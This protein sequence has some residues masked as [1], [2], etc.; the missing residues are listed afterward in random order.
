[1]NRT[2]RAIVAGLVLFLAIAA[3]AVGGPALTA[4]AP[5]TTIGPSRSP[6]LPY[7]EGILG[8]PVSVSPLATRTQADRDL[9]A[10][11]FEGLD[12]LDTDGHPIPSLAQSWTMDPS[13][14]SWTFKLRPDAT[15]QDGK[16]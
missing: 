8:R 11:I 14:A 3:I 16:L 4:R 1:M 7:R 6:A 12:K 5:G 15:W 10:L 13:G 2:D 9:V